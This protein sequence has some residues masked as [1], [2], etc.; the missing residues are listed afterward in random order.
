[1]RSSPPC[2][3]LVGASC[4]TDHRQAAQTHRVAVVKDHR[5]AVGRQPQVSLDARADDKGGAE[6]GDA[7]FGNMRSGNIGAMQATVGE[8]RRTGIE[9]IRL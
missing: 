1:M 4:R 6:G 7:V 9:R 3:E 5:H 8:A 2:A